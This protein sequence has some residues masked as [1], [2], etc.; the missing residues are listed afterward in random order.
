MLKIYICERLPEE[1]ENKQLEVLIDYMY[2]YFNYQHENTYLVI[3]PKFPGV[4]KQFDLLVYRNNKFAL[5]EMKNIRGGFYPNVEYWKLWEHI[6]TEGKRVA[7]DKQRGNPFDQVSKQKSCFVEFLVKDFPDA[8]KRISPFNLDKGAR[9]L[10]SPFIVTAED[11]YPIDYDER[12]V[13]WC[14]LKPIS[15]DLMR[16]LAIVSTHDLDGFPLSDFEKI[17]K[18]INA[19]MTTKDDWPFNGVFPEYKTSKIF[20]CI[21]GFN[22][23][24]RERPVLQTMSL[25]KL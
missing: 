1:T 8:I 18:M 3:N 24:R 12:A 17:L 2:R 21:K 6:N 25:V 20:Y 5:I 11:S 15:E 22:N 14:T 10:I 9:R 23:G 16:R 13:G 7:L 4:K 19:T